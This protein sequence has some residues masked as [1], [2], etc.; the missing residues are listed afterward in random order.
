M[1]RSAPSRLRRYR[2][3]ISL[4]TVVVVLGAVIGVLVGATGGGPGQTIQAQFAEA[5]GLYKGNNVEVVGIKVGT[6]TAIKP[7]PDY[8]TVTMQINH[9]VK[10]PADANAV[11]MAPMVVSDRFVQ[12]EPGYTSG[13]T[14][15]SGDVIPVSKTAIP[16]S[17]DQVFSTLNTLAEQLGPNGANKNGAL[18]D[19]VH[20]LATNFGGSG[21]DFHNAVVNFSQALNGLSANS[22]AFAGTLTNLGG[23]SKALGDNSATYRSFAANL[24]AVSQ[25][26]ANDRTD[27]SAVL[28]SLQQLFASLTTFIHQN[29][30]NLGSSIDNL[31]TFASALASEQ[32]ALAQAYQLSPL[33][34]QNLDNAVDKNAPG[35][36]AI[37]G[38]YDPVGSTAGLFNQVCG[39]TA[40]RFL[41]ILASGTQTNPLTSANSTDTNCAIGNALNALTPPPNASA[42]PDLTLKALVP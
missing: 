39:S 13:P 31:R 4:I 11:L 17:V 22:G 27:V 40:L 20:Q 8:V 14:L 19:L 15:P 23:L 3:L 26:L 36:P 2:P 5:P 42:G 7:G 10:I 32:Q 38:R 37:R 9:G 35:G 16:Q 12:L 30:A 29:G 28:S 18:T 6:V 33:A 1:T 21:P 24:D 41:V 25:I 34:L